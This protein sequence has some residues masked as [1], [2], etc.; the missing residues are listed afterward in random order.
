MNIRTKKE[1]L[2]GE[3][4][5]QQK[6]MLASYRLRHG[7]KHPCEMKRR[8]NQRE[9]K[10]ALNDSS[11]SYKKNVPSYEKGIHGDLSNQIK[12]T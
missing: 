11:H 8:M 9:K 7:K 10:I 1:H 12:I 2:S 4:Y 5:G 6:D 3:I